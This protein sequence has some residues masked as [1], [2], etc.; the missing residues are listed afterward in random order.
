MN[1]NYLPVDV[2]IKDLAGMDNIASILDEECLKKIGTC[3]V[4]EY[5]MDEQSRGPW[6]KRYTQALKLAMQVVENRSYPWP[7]ASNVKFPAMTL[8]SITFHARAYPSLIP[9]KDLVNVKTVGRDFLGVKRR[10]ADRIKMHMN[11]QFLDQMEG[12]EEDMDRLLLTIPITGTEFKKVYYS[13]ALGHNVSRHVLAKDLVVDYYAKSL[14]SAERIT[15]I[16]SMSNNEILEM[17]YSE[18]FCDCDLTTPTD[19]KDKVT[20]V[21]DKIQGK[22]AP[23][24]ASNASG[25]P[26]VIYEQHRYYDLDGDGYSEPYICTVDRD[27]RQVLRIVARFKTENVKVSKG[28]VVK[29]KPDQY[30]VKYSFIPSPDG[31]FYDIGFGHLIG[32]LNES[33]NTILN[34]LIDAGTLANM[35]SGF[36]SK[37]FKLKGGDLALSPGKWHLVNASMQDIRNGILPLPVKEPSNVLFQLL[38]LLIEVSQKITSTTDMMVGENPGQ[39]QKATTTMQVVE[40]GMR[41]FTAIYKRLRRSLS[42]EILA[43]YELNKLYLDNTE[44]FTVIDPDTQ[45]QE[46]LKV[47][48]KDYE[49]ESIDV[50]PTSDPNAISGMQKIARA[51]FL[52]KMIQFGAPARAVLERVYDAYEIENPEQ[53]LPPEQQQQQPPLEL[54]LKDRE[55]SI[56]E[57]E[58][59]G[60]LK[61]AEEE[62]DRKR[63]ETLAKINQGD[64]QL[65]MAH[66]VN[67]SQQLLQSM[68]ITSRHLSEEKKDQTAK[69]KAKSGGSD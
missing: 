42:K 17:V 40:N 28:K 59:H 52:L 7:N 19:R 46:Q 29:I 58:V 11:Y 18:L 12:W 2:S 69:T 39:N 55:I 25:A 23:D 56:K 36:I 21:A 54:M 3:V 6:V 66:A 16:M 8:A 15:E 32:P 47:I 14:E 45:D 31:G 22:Q 57:E 44:Y 35:Q 50:I 26:R 53:V 61:I 41:V 37:S 24:R 43:V 20:E 64:R 51:E 13:P 5:D 30:Y 62:A 60:K 38:S 4:E 65:D 68:D 63:L 9:S 34:Q 48:Q 33:I 27:T 1:E 49:D 10:R 67:H